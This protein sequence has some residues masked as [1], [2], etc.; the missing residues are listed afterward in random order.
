[1]LRQRA[2]LGLTGVTV[3]L[4]V[5]VTCTGLVGADSH[6]TPFKVEIE[7]LLN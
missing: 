4:G 6:A 3:L 2:G 5:T 7:I 1:M